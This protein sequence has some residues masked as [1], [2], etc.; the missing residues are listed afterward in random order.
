MPAVKK[1]FDRLATGMKVYGVSKNSLQAV[2][3][4]VPSNEEQTAIANILF[5]MDTEIQTLQQRLSK[6]RQIKQG[7]MQELLT[8]K[9]RLKIA[10][11]ETA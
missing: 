2:N 11:M 6:T 4:P 10:Q 3:I 1:S 8:G 9:T 7:M 5:D